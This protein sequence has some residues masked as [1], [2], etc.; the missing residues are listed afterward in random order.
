M[1]MM[2]MI[3]S[4]SCPCALALVRSAPLSDNNMWTSRILQSVRVSSPPPPL[5]PPA[6]PPLFSFLK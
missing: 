1:M 6:P 2:M 5:P 3:F 4:T